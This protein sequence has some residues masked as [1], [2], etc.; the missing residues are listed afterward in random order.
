ML[1]YPKRLRY[2]LF[3]MTKRNGNTATEMANSGEWVKVARKHYAHISGI[4]VRY[5]CNRWGWEVVGQNELYT[6]LWVAKHRA[7]VLGM[8]QMPA[9]NVR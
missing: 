7:E 8:A 3:M 2:S 4:E 1:A 6:A 9:A 5:D